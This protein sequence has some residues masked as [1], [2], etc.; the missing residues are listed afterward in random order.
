M[1]G[2]EGSIYVPNELDEFLGKLDDYMYRN[3]VKRYDDDT[4]DKSIRSSFSRDTDD[5]I[6]SAV[7]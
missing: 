7:A 2:N 4:M 6:P 5:D 3:K 1:L